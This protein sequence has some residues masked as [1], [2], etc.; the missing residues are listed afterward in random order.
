MVS[1]AGTG[2][3]YGGGT[4]SNEDFTSILDRAT[5]PEHWT[6]PHPAYHRLRT[7]AP[8]MHNAD[9]DFWILTRYEDC[10]AVLRD[11]KWS[12]NPAHARKS[13]SFEESSM[14]ER[15]GQNDTPILLF[16]DPPDHTRLRRIVHR[17]FTPKAVARWRE[18][19]VRVADDLL[20]AAQE[21]GSLEVIHEYA[22][23]LPITVICEMLGVPPEDRET[24]PFDEWSSGASRLL[25]GQLDPEVEMA[26]V[27][28]A[29]QIINYFNN[30]IED[31]RAKP[32][33]DLLSAMIH[34]EDD[35]DM[36]DEQELRMMCV[37]L[38]IAGHE[39]TMNLIGNG[40]LALLRNRDQLELLQRDPTLIEGA[41]EEMLRFDG[42]V[43]LTGRTATDDIEVHGHTFEAG[44]GVVT[45]L[46]AANRDPERFEDPDRF[47]IRRS[48]NHHLTFS[49]GIHY[50]LGASL[51]RLEGQIA[52]GR[53][54]GRF[55]SLELET[56]QP[57]YREHFVLRGLRELRVGL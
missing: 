33:D 3:T 48:E 20:D 46:A 8:M 21:R 36:L 51:A 30:L 34:A 26:S 22:Y 40:T 43:H 23:V 11:P 5:N 17:S 14:R 52:M 57:E 29:M 28:S 56:T 25:D 27:M 4:V 35:G 41:I 37:L 7:H 10:L 38:F 31:R 18:M 50:C 2:A 45:L 13:R 47:D 54:V 44:E 1:G 24:Q 53:L 42:P 49:Q 12:S 16:M 15:A 9:E 6:D 55:P 39:T 19:I 32:G